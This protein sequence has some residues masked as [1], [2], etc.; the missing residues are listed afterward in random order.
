M[1]SYTAVTIAFDEICAPPKLQCAGIA[2]GGSRFVRFVVCIQR[3]LNKIDFLKIRG[4]PIYKIAQPVLHR[5]ALAFQLLEP[6]KLDFQLLDH[7]A[8][9]DLA[10]FE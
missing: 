9:I 1:V 7:A 5:T 3:P 6:P 10:D 4:T 2:S 8:E